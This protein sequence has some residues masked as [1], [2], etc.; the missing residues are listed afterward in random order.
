MVVLL[1][2]HA[3]GVGLGLT[4]MIPEDA[5]TVR[6]RMLEG[7]ARLRNGTY[8][9]RCEYTRK[10]LA[11]GESA[12]EVREVSDV[13]CA[14]DFDRELFRFERRGSR[15]IHMQNASEVNEESIKLLR[16]KE[17][18]SQIPTVPYVAQGVWSPQYSTNWMMT[19]TPGSEDYSRE[20]IDLHEP[21]TLDV[22]CGPLMKP[23]HPSVIGFVRAED[24]ESGCSLE[25][26]IGREAQRLP[27]WSIQ[28][29]QDGRIEFT[30]RNSGMQ[31]VTT[32]DPASDY[33]PV[34]F[35]MTEL[36]RRIDTNWQP[37]KSCK[38][39]WVTRNAATVPTSLRLA[40]LTASGQQET[41]SIDFEWKHVNDSIHPEEHFTYQALKDIPENVYV[42]ERRGGQRTHIDTIGRPFVQLGMARNPSPSA[43]T[44]TMRLTLAIVAAFVAIIAAWLQFRRRHA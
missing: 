33:A 9:A 16:D 8:T 1:V 39:L 12:E 43:P 14:F 24:L 10:E 19:G 26:I 30:M 42:I 28:E 41:W 18:Q 32:L 4:A 23:M 3:F 29:R 25:V 44:R 21:A 40:S 37:E 5:T 6:D 15:R 22:N 31:Q 34:E 13:Y 36:E 27:E 38:T 7:R 2:V 20:N 17:F 35:R 11:D